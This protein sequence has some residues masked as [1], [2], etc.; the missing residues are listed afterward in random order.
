[1]K[2][3]LSKTGSN[4]EICSDRTNTIA[5]VIRFN[6]LLNCMEIDVIIREG[7]LD[8]SNSIKDTSSLNLDDLIKIQKNK[9]NILWLDIKNLQ[10]PEDCNNLLISLKKIYSNNNKINLF[11]E[12]PSQII[13]EISLYEKCILDLKSMNFL[14]SYKIPKDI[15]AKCKEEMEFNIAN[16]NQCQFVEKLIKK[17]YDSKIFTDISFDYQNLNLIKDIEYI[18]KFFL[19]TRNINDDD[20]I[21]ISRDN[22]RLLSPLNDNINYN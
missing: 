1:M 14:I 5:R 18:D 19:N 9:Q 17:I 20:I 3:Y 10:K 13:H 22:F 16:I 15:E 2:N 11:L 4:L 7:Y 12:F 8:V 21:L 6:A